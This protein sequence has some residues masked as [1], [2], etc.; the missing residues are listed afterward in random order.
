MESELDELNNETFGEAELGDWE[1]EH[2]KFVAQFQ[3]ED[4]PPNACELPHFWE[5][6]HLSEFWATD[7]VEVSQSFDCLN[8][9]E[10]LERLVCDEEFDD[11]AILDVL[12]RTSHGQEKNPTDV[13]VSD[14]A[15]WASQKPLF[16][17][18]MGRT[19]PPQ[20]STIS[21]N[22]SV[23]RPLDST[24][25][26]FSTPDISGAVSKQE[27][28]PSKSLT[29]GLPHLD[30]K[31]SWPYAA[32]AKGLLVPPV[33]A[34]NVKTFT[35]PPL[36][37]NN[38]NAN[39]QLG[40]SQVPSFP[41]SPY[42]QQ[43]KN[44]P[45]EQLQNLLTNFR[46]FGPYN[47]PLGPRPP[48][49]SIPPPPSALGFRLPVPA[50][51]PIRCSPF[52]APP[53]STPPTMSA[54]GL[55]PFSPMTA[56]PLPVPFPSLPMPNHMPPFKA[57]LKAPPQPILNGRHI[58]PP[59][60]LSNA[61][62][63]LFH[64]DSTIPVT[65][66][67]EEDFDPKIGSWMTPRERMLVLHFQSR[68]L[69]VSNPYVEDYYFAVKWLRWMTKERDRK[70]S[71]GFPLASL[72]PPFFYLNSPVSTTKLVSADHHHRLAMRCRF[73]VPI[74]TSRSAAARV[75]A[76][77]SETTTTPAPSAP[78]QRERLTSTSDAALTSPFSTQLGRP[79]K[80]NF[81]SQRVIADLSV[82]TALADNEPSAASVDEV[83][84][85][86]FSRPANLY[87]LSVYRQRRRLDLLAR[88]ERLYATVLNIDETNVALARIVV[89]NEESR[90]LLSHRA[91]L[92]KKLQLDL[93]LPRRN[94]PTSDV[95]T[96]S[97]TSPGHDPTEVKHFRQLA[98]EIF[99]VPKGIR[100]F[101]LVLRFLCPADVE[102]CVSEFF[103]NFATINRLAARKL[104]EF[105]PLLYESIQSIIYKASEQKEFIQSCVPPIFKPS[106]D[107]LTAEDLD[108]NVTCMFTSKLGIS[109]FL[110]LLDACAR[111]S[112]PD[113]P[114]LF[115]EL[116]FYAC[117]VVE[118][119]PRAQLV[120]PL[121]NF[122]HFSALDPLFLMSDELKRYYTASLQQAGFVLR[123]LSVGDLQ[124]AVALTLIKTPEIV[125]I[126]SA[127]Q[128]SSTSNG[129]PV[130]NVKLTWSSNGLARA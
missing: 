115:C 108:L 36:S 92:L 40:Q 46:F 16:A 55:L 94:S 106:K 86:P 51:L 113:D 14:N 61:E 95:A 126:P 67:E 72:P 116:F 97:S 81:N 75:T 4:D 70:C 26:R 52:Q 1:V 128:A 121:E 130:A 2:E 28:N 58:R 107:F 79:T 87:E 20:L 49:F 125:T 110:C 23:I 90:H 117:R 84:S 85:T 19:Q 69:T 42:V 123:R 119:L 47:R 98:L 109:L 80:S 77:G 103:S 6:D 38:T 88:I 33:S 124:L 5:A 100:L 66:D 39:S 37:L 24:A 82:A 129:V 73:I 53:T 13:S 29:S 62:E 50:L 45:P 10:N 27:Q 9:E 57:V 83:S 35:R 71:M 118:H 122:P 78:H 41:V 56:G 31:S 11:P 76:T 3:D 112:R 68:S 74:P 102:F 111:N 114:S 8:L 54:S 64:R 25:D 89:K 105:Q 44:I 15:L 30:S 22:E 60:D 12:K 120:T 18:K 34:S 104:N 96:S 7:D 32:A 48:P 93:F 99:E 63:V 17:N 127:S 21:T 43:L 65:D 91:N 59:V 101:A